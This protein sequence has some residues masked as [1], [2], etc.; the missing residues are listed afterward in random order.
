MAK[1]KMTTEEAFVIRPHR[2][3]AVSMPSASS[4]QPSRILFPKSAAP[5]S[6]ANRGSTATKSIFATIASPF[7]VTQTPVLS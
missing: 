2:Y 7:E 3:R 6:F 4:G 5:I 1:I